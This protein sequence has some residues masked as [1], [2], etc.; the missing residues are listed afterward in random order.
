MTSGA[1]PFSILNKTPNQ[2]WEGPKKEP[3][4][5]RYRRGVKPVL[6]GEDSSSEDENFD[7]FSD[8][9]EAVSR[10]SGRTGT[11]ELNVG[12]LTGGKVLK[13][14]TMGIV[15]KIGKMKKIVKKEVKEEAKEKKISMKGKVEVVKRRRRRRKE[16]DDGGD[17]VEG[18]GDEDFGMRAKEKVDKVE[19]VVE[20]EIMEEEPSEEEEESSYEDDSEDEAAMARR[21]IKRPVFLSKDVRLKQAEELEQQIYAEAEKKRRKEAIK[22]QNKL[23]IVEAKN[24]RQE[25]EE[26]EGSEAELPNDEDD[27]PEEAY[28]KWKVRELKRLNRDRLKQEA[29][30]EAKERTEK[31]RLMTAEERA[32]DD[33]RIGKYKRDE[34]S[35]YQFMQKYYHV[36]IFGDKSDPIFQRDYNIGVGTDNF[37]K[38]NLLLRQQTRRGEE[39]KR[40]KSKYTH[41]GEEDTTNFDPDYQVD[42]NLRSSWTNR[43]AGYKNANLFDRPTRKRK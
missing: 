10:F 28:E 31:R 17:I 26:L 15:K 38:T 30:F 25:I 33:K 40:G 20:E 39:H 7:M 35:S 34:K 9:K 27:P 37:D 21:V 16:E 22:E 19:E 14:N 23:L 1:D 43:T 24:T 3:K 6:E 36:G 18:E 12:K 41:L 2:M 29:E 11:I 5:N 32:K 4:V 8:N 42:E 13:K